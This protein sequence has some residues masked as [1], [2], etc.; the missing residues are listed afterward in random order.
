VSDASRKLTAVGLLWR[1]ALG[2]AIGVGIVVGADPQTKLLRVTESAAPPGALR[3]TLAVL[4]IAA[5]YFWGGRVVARR[6]RFAAGAPVTATGRPK[7]RRAPH[8]AG[9]GALQWQV[10]L[11]VWLFMFAY[12]EQW[13]WPTV[14]LKTQ[15]P[16]ALSL[17]V[18]VGV[19]GALVAVLTAV[20]RWSGTEEK[21]RDDSM[22]T[23]A[24]ICPRGSGQKVMA[25]IAFCLLN[26]VIEELLFR[27]VLVYQTALAIG[28]V[29][30]PIAAGLVINVGNHWYQGRR[31]MLIHVPFFATAVAL[32]FSPLGLAGA[33]GFHFAGD[34]VPMSLTRRQLRQ[35]RARHRNAG[36]ANVSASGGAR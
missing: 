25:W 36:V 24:A 16:I 5:L 26:P 6:R 2:A 35:F 28:S 21:F 4:L 29:W 12:P 14:G 8:R 34:I 18:G 31:S 32:L 9:Y 10:I 20:M 27:G 11:C 17:V 3:M 22:R 30:L 15:I 23:M 19:Y 13:T 7:L 1:L 33:I